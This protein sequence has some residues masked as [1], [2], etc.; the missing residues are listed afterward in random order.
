MKFIAKYIVNREHFKG[1]SDPQ[2]RPIV[3][4]IVQ[5][6]IPKLRIRQ[7]QLKK[8]NQPEKSHHTFSA[9]KQ[10]IITQ[11]KKNGG[12]GRGLENQPKKPN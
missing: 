12:G 3:N 5:K 11:E 2:G 6:T 1:F 8:I 10:G 4:S 7:A 9:T